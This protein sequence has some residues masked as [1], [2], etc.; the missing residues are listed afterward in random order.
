LIPLQSSPTDPQLIEVA[1][2][3]KRNFLDSTNRYLLF[4]SHINATADKLSTYFASPSDRPVYIAGLP[5]F[6][7]FAEVESVLQNRMREHPMVYGNSPGLS[8]LATIESDPISRRVKSC[9][10]L[11]T[12]KPLA[13]ELVQNL[14]DGSTAV[15]RELETL[16]RLSQDQKRIWIPAFLIVLFQIGFSDLSVANQSSALSILNVFGVSKLQSGEGWENVV[17]VAMYFR[18]LNYQFNTPLL[19]NSLVPPLP[20]KF[21]FKVEYPERDLDSVLKELVKPTSS[22]EVILSYPKINSFQT[23]D[24]LVAVHWSESEVVIWGYQC[25]AGNLPKDGPFSAVVSKSFVLRSQDVDLRISN[26][27]KGIFIVFFLIVLFYIFFIIL[28]MFNYILF[29]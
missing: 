25:K 1:E 6:E 27:S 9:L 11:L 29:Y 19:S 4:S 18:I 14:M 13:R 15:L 20:S 5:I 22:P 2:F 10:S 3:L 23:Y 16:T 24:I 17:L 26:A 21:K 7:S 28:I 12:E 8:Y